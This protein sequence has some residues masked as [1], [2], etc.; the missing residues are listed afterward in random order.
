MQ[1]LKHSFKR[2]S[3]DYEYQNI[4]KIFGDQIVFI[5]IFITVSILVGFSAASFVSESQQSLLNKFLK[6]AASDEAHKQ[7]EYQTFFDSNPTFPEAVAFFEDLANKNGASDALKVLIGANLPPGIDTHL[8]GHFVGNILYKQKGIAGLS[9][10]TDDLGFACSHSIVISSL[11]ENGLSVFDTINYVCKKSP[12]PGAYDMCFHGFGHGVLAFTDYQLPDAIKLCSKVGT[13]EYNN[14][15]S[16]ECVGGVIM[17]MRGGIHDPEVWRMNGLKYLDKNDPTKMCEAEYM[18]NE[19]KSICYIYLTPFLFDSVS[20]NDIPTKNEYISAMTKC[21]QVVDTEL[22]KACYGGFAKEFVSFEYGRDIRKIASSSENS[23]THMWKACTSAPDTFG[24]EACIEYTIYALYRNGLYPPS[25]SA[26]FCAVVSE[27][28]KNGCYQKAFEVVN[29]K[30]T[31]KGE[32]ELFCQ[33]LPG[34][35]KYLCSQ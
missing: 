7:I 22:R 33:M 20:S 30:Q 27:L 17:E 26:R 19:F 1:K 4:K 35:L 15:E 5:L 18:P 28:H 24:V 11:L 29:S 32:F 3:C 34:E 12:G 10:C 31:E 23:L 21:Q 8:M 13:K 2:K 25:L 6:G 9:D 16:I 14:H